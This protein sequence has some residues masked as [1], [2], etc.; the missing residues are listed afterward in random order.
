MDTYLKRWKTNVE[1]QNKKIKAIRE[2]SLERL[3]TS[4]V[5]KSM[6]PNRDQEKTSEAVRAMTESQDAVRFGDHLLESAKSLVNRTSP[7]S[8]RKKEAAVDEEKT[9][10]KR[11]V[12]PPAKVQ[13][14]D[15]EEVA[16]ETAAEP[17][18]LP[19][20]FAKKVLDIAEK[21]ITR[22]LKLKKIKNMV[23][24]LG[25]KQEERVGELENA[26]AKYRQQW[27]ATRA[28]GEGS[29]KVISEL[30]AKLFTSEKEKVD[31]R[32]ERDAL[33]ARSK[34]L[35]RE[36]DVYRTRAETT[37]MLKEAHKT[38]M[39]TNADIR[40]DYEELKKQYQEEAQV[41]ETEL[42]TMRRKLE[43]IAE[44]HK[45]DSV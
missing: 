31:L 40:R 1:V 27:E 10:E 8:Q 2:A 11:L 26:A 29:N 36:L 41:W 17:I 33:Q 18:L 43:L 35:Q 9:A 13:A 21:Q 44:Y 7:R 14:Q 15:S 24:K 38:V 4:S 45:K 32:V 23:K 20:E 34:D 25:A 19:E 16:V 28:K 39:E 3:R 5:R 42:S 22:A 30:E 6:S 37:E 12:S